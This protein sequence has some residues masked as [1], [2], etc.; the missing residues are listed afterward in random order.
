MDNDLDTLSREQWM[1]EVKKLRASVPEWPQFMRGCV[2]YRQSLDA[3][4]PH[5]PRSSDEFSS[6]T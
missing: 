3:Q 5:A 4:T 1:T 6:Q 2:K